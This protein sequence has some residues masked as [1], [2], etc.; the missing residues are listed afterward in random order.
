MSVFKMSSDHLYLYSFVVY[1]FIFLNKLAVSHTLICAVG[2][3]EDKVSTITCPSGLI[4]SAI[5]FASYGNSGGSCGS[6]TVGPC[7]APSSM[8][9]VS[10]ECLNQSTCSMTPSHGLFDYNECHNDVM[11][12]YAEVLCSVSNTSISTSTLGLLSMSSSVVSSSVCLDG[13]VLHNS[14]CYYFNQG[15][16]TQRSWT[17]CQSY[18][19]SQ[20][21]SMLC[22][23]DSTTNTWIAHQLQSQ[24]SVSY[25]WIGY[26]N[27]P[28]NEYNYKWVSGCT[29]SY[30]NWY[31][32]FNFEIYFA[33]I[34]SYD[35]SWFDSRDKGKLPC[36]CE[37][38]VGPSSPPTLLPTLPTIN[39]SNLPTTIKPS[40]SQTI[41]STFGCKS[42]W[43]YNN[44]NNI[45]Y[46]IVVDFYNTWSQCRSTCTSLYASM[47]CIPDS[48]TNSWIA[49][50]IG[51]SWIGYEDNSWVEG[52][53]S[54]YNR[55]YSSS[56]F[57]GKCASFNYGS[58][59]A[60][61]CDSYVY[62]PVYA[63][64]A[65]QYYLGPSM[66]PTYTR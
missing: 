13:W 34:F 55:G 35:G 23:P 28:N 38:H 6:Y 47:L 20:G 16:T 21:A 63:R 18:C 49:D 30:S 32:Y 59:V 58:W 40:V 61:S 57:N 62:S 2:D 10:N 25:T 24:V 52:C 44:Y 8:N 14:K 65:C 31:S 26:T 37:Y 33:Y 46:Y 3:Q 54:S 12:L 4:I 66:S 22:I 7:H 48:T 60:Y 42:G 51:H 5:R 27:V 56:V 50:Q 43:K 1:Y 36:S 15:S 64:C 45:C 17:D 19:S 29:S 9:I 41:A 39:P 11:K 53:S